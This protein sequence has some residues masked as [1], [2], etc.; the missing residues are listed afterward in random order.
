MNKIASRFLR[1]EMPGYWAAAIRGTD[2]S[3]QG[4]RYLCR[5]D[6]EAAAADQ[7]ARLMGATHGALGFDIYWIDPAQLSGRGLPLPAMGG[8]CAVLNTEAWTRLIV[9]HHTSETSTPQRRSADC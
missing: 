2:W 6:S 3:G 9:A 5:A 4:H 7:A 8:H 1:S